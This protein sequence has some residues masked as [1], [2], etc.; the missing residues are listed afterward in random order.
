LKWIHFSSTSNLK[1][2]IRHLTTCPKPSNLK[3][4]WIRS[5]QFPIMELN[6]HLWWLHLW[7]ISQ[8][9]W[10]NFPLKQYKTYPSHMCKEFLEQLET[11]M[12]ANFF[13]K[14]TPP[15]QLEISPHNEHIIIFITYT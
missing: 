10:N 7:F 15:T 2:L 14:T 12:V 4:I 1:Q 13:H 5:F 8:Y 6:D 11:H 9:I 3:V